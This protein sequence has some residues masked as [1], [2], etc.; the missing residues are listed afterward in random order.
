MLERDSERAAIAAVLDG[1]GGCVLVSGPAGIGKTALLAE[2]THERVLRARGSELE[3]S[4]AFGAVQQLFAHVPVPYSGAARHAAGAFSAG[5]E[6]DHAVLHGLYW[7]TAGLG[8]VAIVVDDAHWL[9]QP[10]LRW[11]AYMV[12]RVAD[13]PLALV[14]AARSDEQDELLRRIALHPST[15]VVT[16]KP[17][18]RD[19]VAELAGEERA[20]AIHEA[21]GGIP[22]YV[23]AMAAS[24]DDSAPRSVVE[25]IALRLQ[26]LEPNCLRLARAMAVAGGG[27]T[28]AARLAGLDV[29]DTVTAAEAL[30]NAE[31]LDGDNFAHPLV[32]QAIYAA[33]P[34]ADRAELHAQAAKLVT[35]PER[36]AAHVLAAGPGGGVPAARAL[37]EAATAAWARGA[38]ETA[39]AYLERAAEEQLPRG[40]LVPVLR[41]LA[42]AL[43]AT[44]GPGGFPVLR[45]A[46]A[47]A[48]G[49][50]REELVL[51]LGRALMIQGYFSDAAA[52]FARGDGEEARTELATVSVLDLALV[53]GFGG[54][55]ALAA[56]LPPG[57]SAVGAWIEVARTPPAGVGADHAELAFPDAGPTSIAAALIALMA[58]GRL[59]QA[60]ACWTAVADA[61]RA[62]GELER[63]RLAVAL[64]ALVRVRQGRI[65]ETEA[66][67]RELIAWVSE[68]PVTYGDYRIALPWV[69]SP[70]VDALLERGEVAEA[71]EWVRRT[72]LER[73]WPEIFG[74]TFL[75]DTLARLRL[76][77]GRFPEALN[78]AREC[79]RRQRAWGFKNPGFVAWGS[80][81]ALAAH[82]TGR[83][84]EALDAVD[85]QAD[86]AER[87]GV[88]REHGRALLARA[89]ITGEGAERAAAVLQGSEARLDYAHA[90]AELGDRDSLRAALEL[91]ERCGAT[92]LASRARDALVATGARPRRTALTGAAAL[93][94]AQE[95]VARL[96]AG[97]LGNRE[98][99]ELLF[100][101]EKTVEGHLGATY[102]KLGIASRSQLSDALRTDPADAA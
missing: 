76:A 1:A 53:R 94:A 86:W 35:G 93:T 88:A 39:V 74:F 17:L 89:R 15:T 54:L 8:P 4:F 23:H 98:I 5:G 24:D 12:N 75:L 46:L 82:A 52:V 19:A 9:D 42:R 71:S 96:A 85:E 92:A 70:L 29:R 16:P 10:S 77:E 99:A 34:A 21:T 78:L 18:S 90:L 51:E 60:D 33:I 36:I 6:P 58:A 38:P 61:A 2:V 45:Q 79:A 32:H 28:I 87:F 11:L 47:L 72:G 31:I 44:K 41:E 55:D 40:E 80:T 102:R 66:D 62:A 91:A 69:I 63:L 26:E 68:L 97:G 22:F 48:S 81:L 27:G 73:D 67:L 20:T 30:A 83:T 13:L 25:S 37:R 100:V 7:L 59:E 65:A 57:A 43:I 3:R 101:T 84:E 64:R 50:E 95:R 14:I 49:D 56:Q